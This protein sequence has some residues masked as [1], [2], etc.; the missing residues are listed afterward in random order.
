MKVFQNIDT[1]DPFPNFDVGPEQCDLLVSELKRVITDL[2]PLRANRRK[3]REYCEKYLRIDLHKD[4]FNHPE[5][6]GLPGTNLVQEYVPIPGE[7]TFGERL[8]HTALLHAIMDDRISFGYLWEMLNYYLDQSDGFGGFNY[9]EYSDKLI[10]LYVNFDIDQI[11]EESGKIQDLKAKALF[12]NKRLT[13]YKIIEST[14]EADELVNARPIGTALK[15]MVDEVDKELKITGPAAGHD[16]H[17]RSSRKSG[18]V[19]TS[20]EGAEM[21]FGGTLLYN[22]TLCSDPRFAV[23]RTEVHGGCLSNSHANIFAFTSMIDDAFR[24]CYDGQS[25]YEES[26]EIVDIFP[27]FVWALMASYCETQTA[28][29]RSSPRTALRKTYEWVHRTIGYVEESYQSY[30]LQESRR[31]GNG[32]SEDSVPTEIRIYPLKEAILCT[33]YKYFPYIIDDIATGLPDELEDVVPFNM[34]GADYEY[35]KRQYVNQFGLEFRKR[36]VVVPTENRKLFSEVMADNCSKYCNRIFNMGPADSREHIRTSQTETISELLHSSFRDYLQRTQAVSQDSTVIDDGLLN[37]LLILEQDL[38]KSL[39]DNIAS[40]KDKF[41][42]LY[43]ISYDAVYFYLDICLKTAFDIAVEYFKDYEKIPLVAPKPQPRIATGEHV[44]N[45]IS[46]PKLE[47]KEPE[48]PRPLHTRNINY[49]AIYNKWNQVAFTATTL[50][51]FQSAI[52]N[53]DFRD[54]LEKADNAGARSGYRGCIKFIIKQLSR[55]LGN[56]WYDIACSNIGETQNSLN[57]LNDGTKQISKIDIKVLDSA[58]K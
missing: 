28:R 1:Y 18:S 5:K 36:A 6:Y 9:C 43:N 17:K 42:N 40:L 13:D 21:Q 32:S 8:F 46:T 16:A 26:H 51:E 24:R 15:A 14:F 53:A 37:W 49:R 33:I 22:L 38:F 4:Q 30:K 56:N 23:L 19:Q 2:I 45:E 27:K 12:L 25:S 35:Y 58:I 34:W 57:K 20:T 11:R 52:D 3:T 54:M 7:V 44:I 48:T 39:N 29:H 31:R 50:E 10:S 55:S 47:E 41:Y